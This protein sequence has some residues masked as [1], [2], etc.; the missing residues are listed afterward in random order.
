M[1]YLTE[2]ISAQTME[3]A[4][5][6]GITVHT[7]IAPNL[8]V[9]G[10]ETML[11][12]LL[13]N[14]MDN[15]VKYGRQN[16]NLWVTLFQH[17]EQV[18]GKIQDDG[19]GIAPEHLSKIWDRFYQVDPSRSSMV[20]GVGLGLSMVQYIVHAHGGSIT[21]ESQLGEGSCFMFSLPMR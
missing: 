12:R 16:G 5:E 13:L 6:K 14:L 3:N 19:I 8:L 17:D 15:G 7:D 2:I 4:Q 9:N 20:G 10:D 21:A 18:Y 11:M 1:S